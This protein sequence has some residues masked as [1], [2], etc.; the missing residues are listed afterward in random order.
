MDPPAYGHSPQGKAWRIERDLWPLI[1]DALRLL[2]TRRSALLITGHSASVD[3]AMIVDYLRAN[4]TPHPSQMKMELG[5]L[6]LKDL[7]GRKLDA[8]FFVRAVRV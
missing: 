5:R 6:S 4:A 8:G 7:A 1:D 3:Q 2:R